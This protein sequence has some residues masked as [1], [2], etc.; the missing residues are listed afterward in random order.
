MHTSCIMDTTYVLHG[1]SYLGHA[2]CLKLAQPHPSCNLI[3]WSRPVTSRIV[4]L[5]ARHRHVTWLMCT[6][7]SMMLSVAVNHINLLVRLARLE[8]GTPG[9]PEPWMVQAYPTRRKRKKKKKRT[10]ERKSEAKQPSY[11]SL[12][13]WNMLGWSRTAGMSTV[14]YCTFLLWRFSKSEGVSFLYLFSKTP[15]FPEFVQEGTLSF[16]LFCFSSSYCFSFFLF[17]LLFVFAFIISIFI[18]NIIIII[19]LLIIT[20]FFIIIIIIFIFIIIFIIIFMCIFA[21]F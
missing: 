15:F 7:V 8:W 1:G 14:C 4:A 10:D 3:R 9:T 13:F 18:T 11:L 17:F 5:L 21:S 19:I 20:I 6:R 12:N 2:V 16:F